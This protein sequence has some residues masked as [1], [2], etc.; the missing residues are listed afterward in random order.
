MAPKKAPTLTQADINHLIQ[1]RVDEAITTERERVRNENNLKG[2]PPGPATG[3]AAQEC[4]FAGFM[5]C[6]PISFHG[7]EGAMGLSRWIE[8]SESVF[9][10]SKCTEG[11]KVMFA[12][13]TLQGLAL[14]WWNNQVATI[15]H[16][17]ANG[18]SW[19][20]M[21]AMMMEEFGPL[22]EIQRIEH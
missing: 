14:T 16:A 5:K 13:T 17:V 7:N 4:T 9:G 3:T 19:T 22:E 18:K 6:N 8:K 20:E 2:P 10:I 1:E 11:N 12:A 15:G 21:K